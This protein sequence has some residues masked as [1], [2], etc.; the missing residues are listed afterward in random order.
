MSDY[1]LLVTDIDGTL[2]DRQ[3]QL[4]FLNVAAL[5]HWVDRGKTLALATGRNLTITRPIAEAIGRDLYLILQDGGLVMRY[6]KRQVLQYHNLQPQTAQ[7][8]RR[9]VAQA[10]LPALVFD[11]LPHGTK[12]TLQQTGPLS[13]GLAAYLSFKT[14]QYRR[15]D[16]TGAPFETA[17]KIVAIDCRANVEALLPRL[18]TR[19]PQARVIQTEAVRLN[20]WFL[21][22]GPPSASKAQGMAALLR[23]LNRRPA[24]VI[25]L[26]DAENDIEMLQAAGLGV[27]MA[28]ASERVRAAA[29]RV[30]A[31]NDEPAL[32]HFLNRLLV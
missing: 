30:I 12:F 11:P 23:H 31:S 22:V 10:S 20:A 2:L 9:I 15:T 1:T 24:E 25:A 8:T 29:G 26:G 13:P 5:R 32:A 4:P 17:S 28:N 7:A 14:G 6:P 27:A 18:K 16:T 21:E 19:L 3:G